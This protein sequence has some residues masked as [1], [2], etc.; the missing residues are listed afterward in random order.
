[1]SLIESKSGERGIFNRMAAKKQV[2]K[3][4]D[5][6]DPNYS[7]GTNPCSEIILRDAEFCNL[8]EVVIRPD[9]KPDTLKEKVRL[10]RY[11]EHGKQH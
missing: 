9:D 10:Q 5:R 4:G 3:L 1:M 6:R 11:L 8:T 7:F 2:E